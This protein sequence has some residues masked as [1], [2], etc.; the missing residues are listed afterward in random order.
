MKKSV[1][2]E[3]NDSCKQRLVI[4]LTLHIERNFNLKVF[5]SSFPLS[6]PFIINH[7]ET[8]NCPL[9]LLLWA[10]LG[11]NCLVSVQRDCNLENKR[12]NCDGTD[13]KMGV[14]ATLPEISEW[15]HCSF[16]KS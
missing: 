8:V 5:F 3:N 7:P 12:R 13:F 11:E 14:A 4:V 6:P 1:T 15:T 9:S 10:T 16:G 2:Y